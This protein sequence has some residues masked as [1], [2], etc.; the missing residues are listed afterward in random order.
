[1]KNLKEINASMY[2]LTKKG[3]LFSLRS[4]SFMVGWGD[5]YGYWKYSITFDDGSHKEMMAHRLVA[6]TYLSNDDE[7]RTFVN[8]ID[9]DKLNN[10]VS[11]LEWCTPSENNYHAYE[12]ELHYGKKPHKEGVPCLRGPYKEGG[13]IGELT[14]EDVHMVCKLLVEGYRDVDISRMTGLERRTIN[15]VRHKHHTIFPE[16]ITL[17]NFHFK[18]EERM[19]P[20]LVVT[21]CEELQKGRGVMELARSLG[22]NRK[23][24]GCIRS[25][26]TFKDISKHYIW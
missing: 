26:K 6:I 5:G 21:I 11:N 7:E 9:G 19:S 15:H 8:H 22:L 12:A 13:C 1:M 20:E 3:E 17:Y 14:E 24:V 23:K 4:N 18:K 2:C 10:C 16:I 25:R